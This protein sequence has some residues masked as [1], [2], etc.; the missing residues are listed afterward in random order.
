MTIMAAMLS[1]ADSTMAC[2]RKPRKLIT[3]ASFT[4]VPV[5]SDPR[6]YPEFLQATTAI[7]QIHHRTRH[8]DR[9]ELRNHQADGRGDGETFY[10]T[11]ANRVQDHGNDQTGEVG[12]E[13]GV[14]GAFIASRDGCLRR[15]AAP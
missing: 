6:S 9:G 8:H 10:R 5:M 11:G 7:N 2:I 3:L 15:Q 13:N 4:I 14:G 12:V 1:S